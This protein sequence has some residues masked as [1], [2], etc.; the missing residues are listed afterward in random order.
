MKTRRWAWFVAGLALCG[1]SR[2]QGPPASPA[3]APAAAA[4]LTTREAIEAEFQRDLAR[5]ER[6]KIARL[7]AL[8]TAQPRDEATKTYEDLFRF[9][10]AAG[11]YDEA[12]PVAE[13]LLRAGGAPPEVA[14]LAEMVNLVAEANRG[15]YEDSLQSLSVAIRIREAAAK[16]DPGAKVGRALPMADRLSL[17]NVYTQRLFRDGQYDAARRALTMLRDTTK[18]APIRDLVA[19]R[20]AQIDRIGKPAP[21]IVGTSIDGGPV[22]LD[23]ARAKGDVVLVVFWA[24]WCLPNAREASGLEALAET[25]RGKGFRVLGVNLDTLQ[26]GGTPVE[27]VMPNVRRFLIEHNVRWP[28]LINGP[29]N[30]DY[31]RAYG[32]TEIPA[33]VLIGRDGKVLRL[34]LD[35]ASLATELAK[36]L[37]R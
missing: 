36:A 26:D 29:G 32:V 15:A 34:D 22:S 10:I 6:S 12:E 33:N 31:A 25:Y 28:N 18:E 16:D 13:H 37:A 21:P 9:A 5:V 19:M 4:G 14:L 30:R 17:I 7:A 8:A 20:L 24:S 35:R 3:A 27:T 1:T 2:G 11:L 23:E